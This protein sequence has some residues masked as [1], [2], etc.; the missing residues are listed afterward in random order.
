M[1][2]CLQ[3]NSQNHYLTWWLML[4]SSKFSGGKCEK[5]T[6]YPKYQ[7]E[8][9]WS[10]RGTFMSYALGSVPARSALS[11]LRDLAVSEWSPWSVLE[12]NH[13]RGPGHTLAQTFRALSVPPYLQ[14]TV[15]Y[16]QHQFKYF[17][18]A[19]KKDV[20]HDC[21]DFKFC[22]LFWNDL[23]FWSIRQRDLSGKRAATELFI[24]TGYT[25]FM[26]LMMGL[27]NDGIALGRWIWNFTW[28]R[29]TIRRCRSSSL[30]DVC[31]SSRFRPEK[32][33]EE[34]GEG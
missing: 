9:K 2:I 25:M 15:I 1:H 24:F 20:F 29:G 17:K 28:M 30:W 27:C 23:Q 18:D 31:L 34:A 22:V 6:K 26:T 3:T 7:S 8:A 16:G 5:W 19:R 33:D 4:F 21:Y 11:H 10:P 14:V 13:A 32:V 12:P